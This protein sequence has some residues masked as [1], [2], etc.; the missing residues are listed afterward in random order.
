[1]TSVINVDLCLPPSDGKSSS[2]SYL[3]RQATLLLVNSCR[4]C[5]YSSWDVSVLKRSLITIARRSTISTRKRLSKKPSTTFRYKR[6]TITLTTIVR[7]KNGLY[8]IDRF[9]LIQELLL[10]H[11]D[12]FYHYKS[13]APT[14]TITQDDIKEITDTLL[15]DFR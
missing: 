13:I 10:E 4:R 8:W 3:K 1:M 15:D 7:F 2:N 5:G 9:S 12:L 14:G 11:A 6:R